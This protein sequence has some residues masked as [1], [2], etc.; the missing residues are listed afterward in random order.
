MRSFSNT[1]KIIL[2]T[3]SCVALLTACSSWKETWKNLKK[4]DFDYFI[5]NPMPTKE[6]MARK[7]T[8]DTRSSQAVQH[9][10]SVLDKMASYDQ[11]LT[12]PM[13]RG[14]GGVIAE[15]GVSSGKNSGPDSK[16]VSTE[17]EEEAP[18]PKPKSTKAKSATP[19][20]NPDA[21]PMVDENGNITQAP[22]VVDEVADPFTPR[23]VEIN[24]TNT[25]LRAVI[26]FVFGEYV[27]KP[28]VISSEFVDKEVNW[29]A[30]GEFTAAEVKRMFETFLDIQGVVVSRLDGIYTITNKNSGTKT[31]GGGEIGT[32]TGVWRL[33]S[34][35]ASEAMQI[36]RP[37][38]ANSEGVMLLDKHNTLIVNGS[39]PEIRYIDAFLRTV[40]TPTFKDKRIIV[41]S[42]KYISAEAMVTLL[43]TLP[44]QLGMNSTEG[45]KQIE[46]AIITGAKRVTIVADGQDTRDIV[47]Q[48]LNQVDQ[49]GKKQ[50]QIF[51]YGL[52]NQVVDD[53]RTTLT[54]LIPGLLPDASDITVVSNV[55][56]NSLV[57]T[58]TADQYFEIKK[59]IDRLDYR[60]PSLLIDA[61]IVEVQLNDNLAYGVEWFLGGRAGNVRGDITTD[62]SN[63]RI[64]TPAARIGVV[65]LANNTFATLDLLSS[66]TSLRVLSRPRVIVKNKATATIKSTDQVRIVKSVLTTSVQQGGDNIPKREFEDKEVGVSLQVTPRIA[67]DGTVNMAVKIQDSRQGAD[68]DSSGE[69]PRFNIREVNTEL[70]TKNGETL[71]IG[72]LIRNSTSRLKTK[73]PFFGD[74]PFFGQAFANTDDQDQ[75][76]E[77][78]IFMTPYLIVDEISAKLVSESLSGLA[79][80]NPD[81]MRASQAPDP[82]LRSPVT[83]DPVAKQ[84]MTG[85]PPE[86]ENKA[87]ADMFVEKPVETENKPMSSDTTPMVPPPPPPPTFLRGTDADE[88]DGGTAG[89]TYVPERPT[90]P[91]TLAPDDPPSPTPDGNKTTIKPANKPLLQ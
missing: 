22:P 11:P 14:E 33:K 57:I 25:S 15:F 34:I 40:D 30:Q 26:E 10:Q 9:S 76:T 56:T 13:P 69:R 91:P 80:I 2:V 32:S 53:V 19:P 1:V 29:V 51:Y 5:A 39:G 90:P 3:V 23:Q 44:Q 88:E 35:D 43:Q 77:L 85:K 48:Y 49:P 67:E 37:F 21:P 74:I 28:Y 45:K 86:Q 59:V 8:P 47:L 63:G 36:V 62:L 61:T 55:P 24:F 87:P 50:K 27:K 65:S 42:P 75:R 20:V 70:V 60:V 6:D 72:G 31:I 66:E 7:D 81:V 68:D 58:C 83:S 71:L 16:R 64:A 4:N 82:D 12:G 78:I 17:T 38:V 73:V 79:S 84:K 41:Y 54:T 89:A 52:R 46:A 18:S